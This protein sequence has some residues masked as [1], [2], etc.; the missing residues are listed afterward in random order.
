MAHRLSGNRANGS[1]EMV[2]HDYKTLNLW[3]FF[4]VHVRLVVSNI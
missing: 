3:I 2:R 4:F 1:K